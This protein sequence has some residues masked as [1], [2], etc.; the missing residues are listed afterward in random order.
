MDKT[1]FELLY[2][3]DGATTMVNTLRVILFLFLLQI[4]HLTQ[5]EK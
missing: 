5:V 3:L 1:D 4:K 2:K